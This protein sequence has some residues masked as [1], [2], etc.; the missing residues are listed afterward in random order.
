MLGVSATKSRT[1]GWIVRAET[2]SSPLSSSLAPSKRSKP[3]RSSAFEPVRSKR[4]ER[5]HRRQTDSAN[6]EGIVQTNP[7]ASCSADTSGPLKIEV[8]SKRVERR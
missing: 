6:A 8:D 3:T 5:V 2:A 7:A 1:G 4:C